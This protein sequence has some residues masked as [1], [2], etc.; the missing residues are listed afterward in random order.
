MSA[1]DSMLELS[2]VLQHTISVRSAAVM[3]HLRDSRD[4]ADTF[5]NIVFATG[6]SPPSLTRALD[7]LCSRRLVTRAPRQKNKLT[8]RITDEGRAFCRDLEKSL[9]T[10]RPLNVSAGSAAKVAG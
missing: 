3:L 6:M 4:G 9:E 10:L 2:A 7:T 1:R 5:K 8:L